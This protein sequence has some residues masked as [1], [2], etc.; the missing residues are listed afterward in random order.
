MLFWANQGRERWRGQQ[1]DDH[2]VSSI[3]FRQA[4][5][6]KARQLSTVFYRTCSIC[7]SSP[8]ALASRFQCQNKVF[9]FLFFQIKGSKLQSSCCI[10]TR[11]C[12]IPVHTV[13]LFKKKHFLSLPSYCHILLLNQRLWMD[14]QVEHSPTL[15]FVLTSGELARKTTSLQTI[16]RSG[17]VSTKKGIQIKVRLEL[18]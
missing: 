11:D 5:K 12:P 6:R 1:A 2:R 16:H 14:I 18:R 3:I 17:Y 15:S 8:S 9:C 10:L 13:C 7:P 4:L